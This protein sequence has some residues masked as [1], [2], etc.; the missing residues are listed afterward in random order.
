M[1]V[2]KMRASGARVH[3]RTAKLPPHVSL[4]G[5]RSRI[6]H[7]ALDHF[8]TTGY[9]ATSIRDLATALGL[10][11]GALYVHFPS[12]EHVLEELIRVGHEAHNR[13]LREAL[14]TSGI[15]AVKQLRAVVRAHVRFHT[16]F[17]MLAVLIQDELHSLGPALAAAS[18]AIRAQS[19]GIIGEVIARGVAQKHFSVPNEFVATA[20]IG[21]MGMRVAH[22]HG[23]DF[24]L[25]GEAVA[26]IH[27]E[28]AVRMLG[29][30]K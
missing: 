3:A 4:T 28:L 18:L 17:A 22:W 19:V 13:Y 5:T 24:E 27:A 29:V 10:Q 11:P 25:D 14:M 23:P 1:G 7:T 8:S 15:N 20:A 2:H 26:E 12:K 21:G 30:K 6:L 9:A 16:D